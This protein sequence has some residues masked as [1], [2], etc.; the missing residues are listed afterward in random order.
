MRSFY[1]YDKID[2]TMSEFL[3]LKDLSNQQICVRAG[4]QN[5]GI[6]RGDH[7][8]ISPTGGLWFTFDVV[9][10][11]PTPSFALF[12]GFCIHHCL[13][14]L[15]EPLKDKLR[16]KWTNDIIY[17]GKKLGGILCRY[18]PSK[19]LYTIGVGLNTNNDIDAKLGKF[20][21]VSLKQ[22][23]GIE[24]ANSFLCRALIMGI[25]GQCQH[26]TN[27]LNYLTYCNNQLFGKNRM[28]HIEISGLEIEAEILGI[29]ASGALLVRKEMGEFISVHTGSIIDFID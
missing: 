14:L 8:W 28:A 9:H 1:Y 24:V 22:I 7:I 2:S 4:T 13:S 21:A 16:I 11:T 5:D 18:Q 27:D 20:G 23:L 3:R 29:D 25:E 17:D 19:N 6:G 26:N 15:F 10:T 12:A